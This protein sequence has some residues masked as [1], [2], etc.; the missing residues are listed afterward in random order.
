MNARRHTYAVILSLLTPILISSSYAAP[1]NTGSTAAPCAVSD[2]VTGYNAGVTITYPVTAEA[3]TGKVYVQQASYPGFWLG[4]YSMGNMLKMELYVDGSQVATMDFTRRK[5]SPL[6]WDSSRAAKGT[7]DLMLRV[8][9]ANDDGTKS[10]YADSAHAYP[11]V[12]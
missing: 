8:Y 10:C 6:L 12:L 2:F 3:V 1:N 5:L 11:S 9:T 7:H 4:D